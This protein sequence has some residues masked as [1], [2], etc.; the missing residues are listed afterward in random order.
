MAVT[1][2]FVLQ[3]DPERFSF[4][5]IRSAL[6][7]RF[8]ELTEFANPTTKES[9]L[10]FH[11]DRTLV[12]IANMPAPYPWTD[13]EGPCSTSILWPQ[14]AADL[15]EHRSHTIVS[16]IGEIPALE[17]ST[18]LTKVVAAVLDQSREALGVYWSNATLLVPRKLFQEF[19]SEVLPYGPPL[20]IWVDFRV[21]RV[22]DRSS[23]GFTTGLAALGHMEFETSRS[24]EDPAS[25]RERLQNLAHYV[26]LNGRVIQDRDT[27]GADANEHITVVYAASKFG[28]KGKVMNLEYARG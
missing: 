3:Q 16:T 12:A 10:T 22:D 23:A 6:A 14:A 27:I 18:L 28:L 26:I 1:V 15:K 19:A 4:E 17:A 11:V 13:L 2:A 20:D 7:S 24:P 9:V 8:P 5:Q 25:L 21:G